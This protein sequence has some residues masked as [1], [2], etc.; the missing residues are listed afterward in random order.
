M[1][2]SE[3]TVLVALAGFAGGLLFATVVGQPRTMN[4]CGSCQGYQ[5]PGL[6]GEPEETPANV[7]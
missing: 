1:K 5:K 7:F 4:R 6:E 3:K 2:D